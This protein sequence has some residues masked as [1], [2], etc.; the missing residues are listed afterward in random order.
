MSPPFSEDVY[1]IIELQF[2][3][4]LR[5][6][7]LGLDNLLST[8]SELYKYFHNGC[9]DIKSNT[10]NTILFLKMYCQKKEKKELEEQIDV[11]IPEFLKLFVNASYGFSKLEYPKPVPV[12]KRCLSF[13]CL[14]K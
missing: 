3:L 11:L 9:K 8:T 1:N 2:G 10:T 13:L 4:M 14:S 6:K 12:K 5:N 7:P